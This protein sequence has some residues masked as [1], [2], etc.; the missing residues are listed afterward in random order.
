MRFWL[1]A[2]LKIKLKKIVQV[3]LFN[4]LIYLF[5]FLY[6]S[7]RFEIW[8][9]GLILLFGEIILAIYGQK[10]LKIVRTTPSVIKVLNKHYKS[11]KYLLL[12]NSLYFFYYQL[13]LYL[14]VEMI[15]FVVMYSVRLF[16]TP[17]TVLCFYGRLGN[18]YFYKKELVM[19]ILSLFIFINLDNFIYS[20][21]ILLITKGLID[22]IYFSKKVYY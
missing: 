15:F 14:L 8:E 13:D 7:L 12:L 3:L 1:S 11:F 17:Y 10:I 16:T 18:S 22:K 21:L 20:L 19:L 5:I 4:N 2:P 9:Y 6:L